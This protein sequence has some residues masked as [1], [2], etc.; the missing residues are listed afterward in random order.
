M[1]A[2]MLSDLVTQTPPDNY[3]FDVHR[4]VVGDLPISFYVEIVARASFMYIFALILVRLTGKRSLGQMSPFDLVIIIALGSAV[5][6]PMF[7]ADV[8]IGHGAL[9]ISIVIGFTMVTSRLAQRHHRIEKLTDSSPS[10]LILDGVIDHDML[11]TEHLSLSEL[12]ESLRLRDLATLS[13]VRCAVLE[14]SGQISV[15]AADDSSD[16]ADLW[17]EFIE[18]R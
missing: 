8:P 2:W 13:S 6:D 1:N 3:E 11:A 10:I 9:V 15:L 17:I 14:P 4:S 7:Y 18:Q 12:R 5:G 16:V